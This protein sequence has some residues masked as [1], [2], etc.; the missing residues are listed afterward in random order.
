MKELSQQAIDISWGYSGRM[1]VQMIKL[2]TIGALILLLAMLCVMASFSTSGESSSGEVV[3]V[4]LIFFLL[5]ILS[6]NNLKYIVYFYT[7]C[8]V[9]NGFTF[10]VDPSLIEQRMFFS[11]FYLKVGSIQIFLSDI[12]LVVG[13]IAFIFEILSQA[14]QKIKLFPHSRAAMSLVSVYLLWGLIDAILSVGSNGKSA[15][16]ES[17]TVWFSGFF[18]ISMIY[19]R[20]ERSILS[21]FRFF[22]RVSFVRVLIDAFAFLYSPAYRNYDRPFGTGTDAAYFALSLIL[23]II[24]N[25]EVVRSGFVRIGMALMFGVFLVLITSRSA[26]LGSALVLLV[27]SFFFAKNR[28]KAILV[29]FLGLIIIGFIVSYYTSN[30]S[31]I[32]N[33]LNKRFVPV[34][35]DY[36]TDEDTSWRLEGWYWAISGFVSHPLT[37]VGFGTYEARYVAGH[38]YQV[39]T[40]NAFM[41][42]AYTM[43]LMGVVPFALALIFSLAI[44]FARAM[45]RKMDEPR[46]SFSISLFSILSFFMFFISLNA[47]M[48]YALSGTI[49]WIF[50]GCASWLLERPSRGEQASAGEV[51]KDFGVTR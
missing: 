25:K 24:L 51:L 14:R 45:D 49:M 32:A 15:F 12:F 28:F 35:E 11:Y 4:A 17:R 47:E 16:G 42:V 9:I 38:W 43:G 19:F 40:H 3:L 5:L 29:M 1:S 6:L 36:Q 2:M 22:V 30:N 13:V 34:A 26:I 46:K 8:A 21:F 31:S 20:E 48:S 18:F 33:Y 10:L 44:L 27:N 23:I 41:D 39:S 7:G 37:G 50:L